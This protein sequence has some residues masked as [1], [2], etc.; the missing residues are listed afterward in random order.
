[1]KLLLLIYVFMNIVVCQSLMPLYSGTIKPKFKLIWEIGGENETNDFILGKPKKLELD[2]KGNLYVLDFSESHILKFSPN[3]KLLKKFG[4]MGSGPGEWISGVDFT[5]DGKDRIIVNDAGNQRLTY[6]DQNGNYLKS[7]KYFNF[8]YTIA[9]LNKEDLVAVEWLVDNLSKQKGSII[10]LSIIKD[11][12]KIVI[13]SMRVRIGFVGAGR[14]LLNDFA[15]P[16][17]ITS[18][19]DEKL[20]SVDPNNYEIKIFDKKRNVCKKLQYKTKR[21]RVSEKDLEELFDFYKRNLGEKTLREIKNSV[22]FPEFKQYCSDI[23]TDFENNIL[24]R[25]VTNS[26]DQNIFDVFD[27]ELKFINRIKLPRQIFNNFI[28]TKDAIYSLDR[29]NGDNLPA[30]RK[31]IIENISRD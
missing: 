31:Y 6:F 8:I 21:N 29:G 2:A 19:K 23:W 1:M 20:V 30:L 28:I 18:S 11:D 14:F 27:K 4:R 10:N 25:V 5:I 16:Y 9:P 26:Q 17:S 3:G 15:S 12:K 13:D 24:I 22:K 7:I